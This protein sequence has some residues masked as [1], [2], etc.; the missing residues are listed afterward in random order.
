MRKIVTLAY[1]VFIGNIALAQNDAVLATPLGAIIAPAS[2]C[3]LTSAEPVTI[4]I[5]NSGPG[6]INAPFYV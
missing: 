4:R 6:T 5:F 2:G 1:L 3:V